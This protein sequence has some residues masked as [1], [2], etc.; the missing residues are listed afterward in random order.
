MDNYKNDFEIAL[1]QDNTYVEICRYIMQ[2]AD[3]NYPSL[4]FIASLYTYAFYNKGLT[5]KQR[6]ALNPHTQL[7]LG[8]QCYDV[9]LDGES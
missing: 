6:L 8:Y 9:K 5:K 3:P 4:P 1:P 2:K 7:F